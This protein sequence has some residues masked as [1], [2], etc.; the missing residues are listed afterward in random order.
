MGLDHADFTGIA[1]LAARYRA[2]EFTPA[3]Y[4]ALYVLHFQLA[5]HGRRSAQRRSRADAKFDAAWL[6]QLDR[7]PSAGRTARLIDL[8]ERYHLRAVRP[9]VNAALIGWLRGEWALQLCERIPGTREVLRMQTRGTRPVTVIADF[10]RLLQP[11]EEKPD[12]FAFVCHDLEHAWQF[13]H[14]PARN[15]E[16]RRF[17]QEL[18]QAI[19]QGAFAPYIADPVFAAK[20]DYLAADMNTHVAHSLQYLRAILLEYFLRAE[21]KGPRAQLSAEAHARIRR[22]VEVFSSWSTYAPALGLIE[23]R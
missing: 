14:D 21:A 2:G 22:C 10:P 1:Q 23:S 20:L 19:E 18:E 11:V 15:Q 4:A 5:R 7:Q 16:Q 6:A 12:A 17:A 8:L 3:E 13:F 9:R